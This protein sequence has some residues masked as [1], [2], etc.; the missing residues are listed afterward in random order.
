MA[1]GRLGDCGWL[2]LP[3]LWSEGFLLENDNGFL[4]RIGDQWCGENAPCFVIAEAGVNHNG[5]L[6]QALA[7]VDVAVAAKA[8]AVKF[9][10]FRAD[11]IVTRSAQKASY[12]KVTTNADE[13]QYDMLKKLELSEHDHAVIADHCRGRGIMFL[14]TPFDESSADMLQTLQMSAYKLSSGEVTNLPL[15][16]HVAKKGKPVLLS[17]GM[18]TLDEVA[19]AVGALRD[20]GCEDICLLQCVSN[21]PADPANANLRAMQTMRREFFVPVGYSDHTPGQEVCLAAVALGA[22][23]I[24]K[25]ITLDK[26]LPG[27]DQSSSIEPDELASLVRGIRMVEMALGDGVKKPSDSEMDTIR[28][29]RR[30]LV[31][32]RDLPVGAVLTE[33]DLLLRRPGDGL[34]PS[35]FDALLGKTLV[36]AMCEG[37]VFHQDMVR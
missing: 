7:L 28:A 10:T 9:Q 35:M 14:S 33:N 16:R 4:F 30:S 37:Q 21:Y 19:M 5:D 8:D 13:S 23:M 15:L 26:T 3:T 34:P 1:G 6:D 17:T 32:A 22:V 25:H 12:Q 36:V 20:A 31:A 24:E 2:K 11:R 18:S 29:A 27:P